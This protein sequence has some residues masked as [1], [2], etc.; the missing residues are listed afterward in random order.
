MSGTIVPLAEINDSAFSQSLLGKG[1]AIDPNEGKVI[2]PEDGVLSTL[3]PTNHALGI[4]TDS[5]VEIL[6]HIGMDTVQ[7]EGKFFN[8]KVK[9]G[10]VIK[11][12]Q[13]LM[14]FDPEGIKAAGFSLVTPV[15]ITNTNAYTDVIET[16]AKT[17]FKGDTLISIIQ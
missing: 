8:P 7:L 16:D 15:V 1:I 11:K 6:I 17:V 13:V 4:E 12:G 10:D 3:F 2:A 5:G 9:Q 14:E